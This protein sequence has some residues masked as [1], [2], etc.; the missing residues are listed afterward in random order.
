[1]EIKGNSKRAAD[2]INNIAAFKETQDNSESDASARVP[3]K[4]KARTG[5]LPIRNQQ[6]KNAPKHIYAQCYYVLFKKAGMPDRKYKSHS[7]ETCFGNCFDQA[8]V[9]TGPL[10]SSS[11]RNLRRNGKGK[12]A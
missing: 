12:L 4:K 6:N 5:V 7:S 1:M 3:H 2:K 8:S 9:K 11:I 10:P